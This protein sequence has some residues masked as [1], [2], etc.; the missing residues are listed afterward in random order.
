MIR[1]GRWLGDG[2]VGY[3]AYH[4]SVGITQGRI[5]VVYHKLRE[6]RFL[7]LKDQAFH[8]AQKVIAT[9]SINFIKFIRHTISLPKL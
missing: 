1:K 8:V 9:M 3:L 4:R 5:Y 2:S 6:V 7:V